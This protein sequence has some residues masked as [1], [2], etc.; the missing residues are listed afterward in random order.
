MQHTHAAMLIAEGGPESCPVRP[1]PSSIQVTLDTYGHLFEG[2]DE[3]AADR[4]DAAHARAS[5]AGTRRR[6]A[7]T[8]TP[9]FPGRLSP[10]SVPY[11]SLDCQSMAASAHQVGLGSGLPRVR[12]VSEG[13]MTA[14]CTGSTAA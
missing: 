1:G 8:R 6:H 2:L 3:A 11:W 7:Q 5:N 14:C 10:R 9:E 13:P 4:L 12:S